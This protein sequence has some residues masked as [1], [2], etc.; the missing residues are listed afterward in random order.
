MNRRKEP[1]TFG[2]DK[3][4]DWLGK[5]RREIKRIEEVSPEQKNEL[6]D[7]GIN[8]AITAWHMGE[9]A[10]STFNRNPTIKSQISKAIGCP[11]SDLSFERFKTELC[12][13]PFGLASL[14]HCRIIT[15]SAKHI[16]VENDDEDFHV[17]VSAGPTTS[18]QRGALG[19]FSSFEAI[20]YWRLKIHAGAKNLSA[21]DAYK[22][23]LEYWDTFFKTYPVTS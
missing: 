19:N 4:S 11:V 10:W 6:I 8:F 14:D 15:T 9:W 3:P 23:V 22:E 20:S 5:L 17:A 18:V 1:A 21:L 12:K 13:S 7:H 16:G 2:F